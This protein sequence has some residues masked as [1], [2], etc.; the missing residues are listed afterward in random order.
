[1]KIY[2]TLFLL[3]IY[4]CMTSVSAQPFSNVSISNVSIIN[5]ATFDF[6]PT[7]HKDGIVF[8]SNN[9]IQ[10]KKKIFDKLFKQRTMSLFMARRDT[11]GLLSAPQPFA[12]ELVSKVHE[13]PIA[14]EKDYKTVYIS[15]NNNRKR[16]GRAKYAD[17]DVDY[18]KIY[19]SQLGE[20]GWST[21]K[22]MA[23]NL[24]QSDACHPALSPDG[25]RIYFSSNRP[26][27]FGGMD[28][29]VC[30]KMKDQ[31]SKP[32]NLGAKVN[33]DK[34]DVFPYVNADGKLYFSSDREGGKGGLDIYYYNINTANKPTA[35]INDTSTPLSIGAP[36]NSE[37]DDFGFIL[38]RNSKNGY[39][40]SNRSGG[41][42]GDDIYA[43]NMPDE[44][45]PKLE[46]EVV[47]VKETKI[48]TPK[49]EVVVVKETKT[50]T[51]NLKEENKKELPVLINHEKEVVV[52]NKPP[53]ETKS[54]TP[55]VE[56]VKETVYQLKNIYYNYDDAS[57]R[58]DASTTL[59][60]LV[61]VLNTYPDMYIELAAYTDSRG[62]SQYNDILSKKRAENAATYLIKRGIDPKRLVQV[63]YGKRKALNDCGG[64]NTPCP[65]GIHQT[66]RR[67][68]VRVIK[69][70]MNDK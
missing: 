38:D 34:N 10:G 1:M 68:E 53:V 44:T 37:N 46:K 17:D 7:F 63:H 58:K 35:H 41:V 47:V 51:P 25:K 32:M 65:E 22:E 61:T 4:F 62:T 15:R 5:T 45:L 11:K 14:F 26:N 12:M 64:N 70:M 36:F 69:G 59:D 8:V 19:V 21:P 29:Y 23:L 16:S 40:T 60:S 67:T 13:G 57:I 66:N 28:L 18:M 31:W 9:D 52:I 33:S 43:F 49:K 55:P 27:G 6:S 56:L 20:K 42:G 24:K 2:K 30:E 50:E 54:V 39:F 3:F 48:E